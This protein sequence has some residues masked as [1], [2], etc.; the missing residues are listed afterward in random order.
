MIY[1]NHHN[2]LQFKI[3]KGNNDMFLMTFLFDLTLHN[4]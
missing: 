4:G 1:V 2:K 3:Q